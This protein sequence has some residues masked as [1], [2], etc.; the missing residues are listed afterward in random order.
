MK[1]LSLIVLVAASLAACKKDPVTGPEGPQGPPGAQGAQGAQGPAGPAG[2]TATGS[3][4]GKLSI[5]DPNNPSATVALSNHTLSIADQSLSTTTSANGAYTL[6]NVA[7][8]MLDMDV[9]LTDGTIYKVQQWPYPGNNN[10]LANLSLSK[11][12]TETVT[13][14]IVDTIVGGQAGIYVRSKFSSSVT[15][16]RGLVV[17]IGS[18]NQTT[19]TDANTFLYDQLS[20]GSGANLSIPIFIPYS[21]IKT[22][23]LFSSGQTVYVN[24]YPIPANKFSYWDVYLDAPVYYTA[25]NAI[26]STFSCQVQ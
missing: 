12:I 22:P 4:Y 23:Y 2:S 25:G 9:T 3:V 13:G 16:T 15:A 17:V 5:I 7:P 1:K 21:S 20:L 18:T 10:L 8:G 24:A 14:R 26:T 19:A 6:S 11:K